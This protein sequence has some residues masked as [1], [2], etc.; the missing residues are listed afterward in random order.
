MYN[1]LTRYE[2]GE[3]RIGPVD[4]PA[5]ACGE[6]VLSVE[7]LV[8]EAYK[9]GLVIKR[10]GGCVYEELMGERSMGLLYTEDSG[11]GSGVLQEI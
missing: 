9:V 5:S 7:L 8:G 3:A 2:D 11:D 10:G 4:D 1:I 6:V